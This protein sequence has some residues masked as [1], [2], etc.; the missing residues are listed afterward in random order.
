MEKELLLSLRK[1]SAFSRCVPI[2]TT[3]HLSRSTICRSRIRHLPRAKSALEHLSPH[4]RFHGVLPMAWTNHSGPVYTCQSFL[5]TIAPIRNP[6]LYWNRHRLNSKR[7]TRTGVFV[8]GPSIRKTALSS[9]EWLYC[10][11]SFGRLYP[12]C[13]WTSSPCLGGRRMNLS[14]WGEERDF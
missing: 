13:S 9:L 14:R 10:G 4:R 3:L 12:L 6:C 8:E 5:C 1:P 7:G 2:G 11:S